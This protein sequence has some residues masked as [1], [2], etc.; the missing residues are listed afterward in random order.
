M[1]WFGLALCVGLP[2]LGF[3]VLAADRLVL[4]TQELH[5]VQTASNSFRASWTDIASVTMATPSGQSLAYTLTLTLRDGTK[6]RISTA[7]FPVSGPG[8]RDEILRRA[9]V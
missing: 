8:L 7:F 3:R 6:R 9:G 5:V 2:I 1:T 4:T